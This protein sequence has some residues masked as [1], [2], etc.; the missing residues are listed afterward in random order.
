MRT[1]ILTALA[2]AS[3]ATSAGAVTTVTST[4]G[5]D[6]TAGQTVLYNFNSGAPAGLSGNFSITTGTTAQLAAAPLG[7]TTPYLVV[8]GLGLGTSGTATLNLTTALP[9]LSFYWGSIDSY[10][11]V[12]FWSGANGTGTNLGSFTGGMIPGATADGS[13]AT[14][15]NNRRVFFNFGGSTAQSVVFNSTAIAF[16]LDDIAT[17]SAVPEPAIWATLIA[18]FGM[19]GVSMRR[20]RPMVVSA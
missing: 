19:I 2:V 17:G 12:T 10:N 6:N 3:T 7:D 8:P 14:A 11:T 13:Q 9:N 18:G 1:M 20:R 15:A 4:A 5:P 16:E